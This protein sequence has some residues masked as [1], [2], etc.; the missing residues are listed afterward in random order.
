M[1][2]GWTTSPA[3]WLR[4]AGRG[5]RRRDAI[6]VHRTD[7]LSTMRKSDSPRRN[8]W[9]RVARREARGKAHPEKEKCECAGGWILSDMDSFEEC[10]YHYNGQPRPEL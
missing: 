8:R 9:Q 4:P 5:R 6:S 10:P 3:R 2:I 7:P 1:G